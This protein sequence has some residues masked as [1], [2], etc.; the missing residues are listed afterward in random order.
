[1]SPSLLQRDRTQPSESIL[2]PP[3]SLVRMSQWEKSEQDAKT[4]TKPNS[5]IQPK[6]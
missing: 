6:G 2:S 4:R 3:A 5:F 1:M